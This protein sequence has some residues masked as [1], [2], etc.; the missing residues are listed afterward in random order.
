MCALAQPQGQGSDTEIPGSPPAHTPP[1][2]PPAPR[3]SCKAGW[4]QQRAP[5]HRPA[6][7]GGQ[8]L[9]PTHLPPPSLLPWAA[10]L[11][12]GDGGPGPLLAAPC[13][14]GPARG[15]R[16]AS[17]TTR[18]VATGLGLPAGQRARPCFA[19][20]RGLSATLG[21]C[22]AE[23]QP[24]FLTRRLGL[25]PPGHPQGNIAHPVG[26]GA[27][28]AGPLAQSSAGWQLGHSRG[29]GDRMRPAPCS[30]P[31]PHCSK[32]PT[33][34]PHRAASRRA[35]AWTE[36]VLTPHKV[37]AT[38]SQAPGP[39]WD[40]GLLRC[41]GASPRQPRPTEKGLHPGSL[42]ARPAPRASQLHVGAGQRPRDSPTDH[43]PHAPGRTGRSPQG[44]L[45]GERPRTMQSNRKLICS[46][47]AEDR[48]K[49]PAPA[50]D[51]RV[52]RPEHRWLAPPQGGSGAGNLSRATRPLVRGVPKHLPG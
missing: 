14:G 18:C 31:L 2:T 23:D 27:Q 51:R 22:G 21:L 33:R 13:P 45:V 24:L 34:P 7:P 16:M 5:Q 1:P 43:S 25:G 44:P 9:A 11:S 52:S 50:G 30:P 49:T 19:G 12:L 6:E 47:S 28:L 35:P 42:P 39:L 37:P 10:R 36:L 41:L 3:G 46:P 48:K 29:R 15:P 17:L 32:T 40:T 38:S 4:R 26:G 20:V 8:A